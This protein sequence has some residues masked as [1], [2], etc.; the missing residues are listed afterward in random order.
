MSGATICQ[1]W[2]LSLPNNVSFAVV[3]KSLINSPL[4]R[5]T[6]CTAIQLRQ[7]HGIFVGSFKRSNGPRGDWFQADNSLRL[8]VV[9][10]LP[11]T[12]KCAAVAPRFGQLAKLHGGLEAIL[13]LRAEQ[14]KQE[15][16][17]KRRWCSLGGGR[18]PP[19]WRYRLWGGPWNDPP[20]FESRQW[21]SWR[22]SS[23]SVAP[24]FQR[25]GSLVLPIRQRGE[26]A[27]QD[28]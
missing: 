24:L 13:R 14:I 21:D 6:A 4:A 18:Q 23:F 17:A 3:L 9:S 22:P 5:C 19:H 7:G 25:W 16:R 8:E 1:I 28:R 11:V 2:D 20:G 12:A 15:A 27:A 10:L 26:V